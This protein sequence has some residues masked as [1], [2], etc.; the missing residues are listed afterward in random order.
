MPEI[1][2]L[3]TPREQFRAFHERAY[4]WACLVVHRRGGKTVACVNE[5][6]TRATYTQKKNARYSYIAPFYRQAKDVAWQYLKEFGAPVIKKVRESELRVELFND[7]W[8]TLYGAD[9]PD[10]LRGIYNDG[11]VL[12]EFGDCR[13]SLWG[14]VVLPTLADRKGWAAFIGT[15]KGKN[16]FWEINRRSIAES[17]KW[18]HMTLKASE[19]GILDHEELMEM[20]AQMTEAEYMQ[21]M[22]CDFEAAVMGTYFADMI[23]Q[24]E[25]VGQIAP[26]LAEYNPELEVQVSSD[27]GYTDS[28]AYWFWQ[29]DPTKDQPI[30]VIDYHEAAGQALPYYFAML[31][32]KPYTY[33]TIWLPHDARSKT[34]QTGKSTVEQF[35]ERNYPIRIVPRLSVQHGIDAARKVLH[36]CAIDSTLCYDGVEALRAYRRNY[37]ELLKQFTDKPLHDW[38]SNGSDSFRYMALVCE[39]TVEVREES[40]R[41]PEPFK[42][43]TYTLDDLWSLRESGGNRFD[44]LRI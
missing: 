12:D 16:H 22:E 13:P 14:Q 35:L 2:L 39:E 32:E 4:R 43:Q 37:N 11:A 5:L 36:Y 9:N 21:E 23:Q 17:D 25:T 38:A 15:P 34:L 8:I 24:L 26:G 28:S 19:S 44:K 20:K 18:Y 10:A 27:L 30:Q 7:S 31:D 1:E 41:T 6:L 42:L 33:Q 40:T 29:E 3:Y